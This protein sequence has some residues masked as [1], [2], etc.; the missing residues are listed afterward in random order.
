MSKSDSEL[1]TTAHLESIL[2]ELRSKQI[3]YFP[4][5]HH[6][7]VCAAH[8]ER[9]IKKHRPSV[10]L[11][12]GPSSFTQQI[13][14]LT[15]EKCISPVAMFTNFVNKKK[16]LMH[17]APAPKDA[18][19]EEEKAIDSDPETPCQV[20]EVDLI[21]NFEPRFAAYYPFCD[22]SPEL[23]A[24]RAGKSIAAKMRFIDLEYAE[25]VLSSYEAQKAKA[26]EQVR[27]E[28]LA[29]DAHLKHS[30]Y[31]KALARNMGC[32]DFN[33]LWDH[34]FESSWESLNTDAFIDRLATYCA[35]ARLDYSQQDLL[36]DGTTAREDCMAAAICEELEELE[37]HPNKGPILVVTGGFH[38]VALPALVK[39]KA[40]RPAKPDFSE[41]ELG[42]WLIRYSFDQLD[43]LAGYSAG[44][45]SPAFYDQLWSAARAD[46]GGSA[47][48]ERLN[49]VAANTLVEIS[50][51]TR[52][53]K[54][55]NPI[56]TPDS[57]AAMQM[58]KQLAAL[59][60]HPWP[61]R[62]DILDGIRSCFIKG[63]IQVEGQI[64]LRMVRDLLAGKRI[65]QVPPNS[66]LPPI[67]NDFY[68][69]AKRF[70]ISL[71]AVERKEH[72]LELYRISRHREMSRFFHR[73]NMLE[74]SFAKLVSGPDFVH[75]RDLDLIQERWESQWS[76]LLDSGLLES[77]TYGAT[78]EEAAS[79]KL[80]EMIASLAA[81]A[82]A[83]STRAVVALLTRACR[84][85]LH[86]R[87]Q[88]L[89]PLID[90]H[91]AEDPSIA[92][93]VQGLSQLELLYHAREP[94]EAAGLISLAR[95]MQVCY[96]RAC[97]LLHDLP[98]C[99][100]NQIEESL[101]ALQML[102]EVLLSSANEQSSF[103]LDPDLFYQG[104]FSITNAPFESSQACII[105]AAAGI[106]HAESRLSADELIALIC[107]YLGGSVRDA[108]KSAGILR[109]LL[110]V[111]SELAWQLKELIQAFDS[112]FQNWDDKTFM[113]QLPE[114]RLAFSLLSPRDIARVAE[115]V[116]SFYGGESLGELL[117]M[118]LDE[119]TLHFGVA[120]NTKVK[121]ALMADGLA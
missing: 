64:L 59:R 45:P 19:A 63:E 48:S 83:R 73:L 86:S 119:P 16:R 54:L 112:Q 71:E 76:P 103:T 2:P 75:G 79:N 1:Q 68:S 102:R 62:E 96:Q 91:I 32:R 70:R 30:E 55:P 23:L 108:A 65:G 78:I 5:R 43:A 99:A 14:L 114:L 6:S 94:L 51:E 88:A 10:I 41:G 81:N 90:I 117:H 26:K 121:E 22:Y 100:D 105:G 25:M 80:L 53:L 69:E 4:I 11:V 42:V 77:S 113:E 58:T 74:L 120:L 87:C 84:L 61:L 44:M 60:G 36:N 9:W 101:N 115:Q 3:T 95:L 85:G 82:N 47:M 118:D 97:H 21:P 46:E 15:D 34:L 40:K 20:Q 27:V 13:E 72:V 116:S 49:K 57:I 109:G 107:G 28:S 92:S 98:Q 37:K 8:I 93:V 29:Q 7:P 31:M 24:L 33:E 35:M 89:V 111:S 38:T 67:F 66:A 56:T 18:G 17:S 50:R 39:A 52:K 12:E 104:L 110:S 106:L